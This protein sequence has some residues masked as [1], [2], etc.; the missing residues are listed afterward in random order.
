MERA[1]EGDG[2]AAKIE[3]VS[4]VEVGRV[5]IREKK[6]VCMVMLRNGLTLELTY[7]EGSTYGVWLLGERLVWWV[8]GASA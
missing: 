3:N 2:M 4:S 1:D 7:S 5:L 6:S 8:V